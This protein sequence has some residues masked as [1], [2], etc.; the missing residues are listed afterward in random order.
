MMNNP[1]QIAE[2][3]VEDWK[4]AC[5]GIMDNAYLDAMRVEQRYAIEIQR[6]QKYTVAADGQ[7]HDGHGGLCGQSQL[8]GSRAVYP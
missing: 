4:R 2:I 6:Y 3:L 8:Q 1:G 7:G 5:R